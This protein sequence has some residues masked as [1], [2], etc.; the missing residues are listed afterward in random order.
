MIVVVLGIVG[1]CLGSFVNAL[2]WRLH[3]QEALTHQKKKPSQQ[4][5][6][7]L[8]ILRGRSMCPACRHE[9]APKD[10]VPVFSWLSLKG[11]CRYCHKPISWQYPLV[12]ALTAALFVLSYVYWP[13]ALHGVGLFEFIIW[14]PLL[15]GLV[16]LFV[17]DA[18]WFLLPSRIIY[19]LLV[20][21][22]IQVTVVALFARGSMASLLGAL[23]GVLMLAGLFYV[24]HEISN[25]Q[26][27]GF[28]DVR[29]AVL[30]GLLAGGPLNSLLLLFLASS[31][32]TVVA[33]PLLF[34]GR[35][36]RKSHLPFGPFLIAAAIIVVLFG[37]SI[38]KWYK[39][40]FG[41]I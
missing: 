20:L 38:T 39:L 15:T 2:V 11:K 36:N 25:G 37:A 35:A 5:L 40:R 16:A 10:L 1:L 24:L 28:G 18:R 21:A 23:V 27:I 6:E 8:S 26:W 31:G 9:L 29:L 13:L 30:L 17:Y 32:G 22:V 3:E 7:K 33:L 19:P 4:Q 41:L 14:L 34:T 12:E